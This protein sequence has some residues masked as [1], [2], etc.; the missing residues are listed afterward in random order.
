MP[1]EVTQNKK[2]NNQKLSIFLNVKKTHKAARQG[3]IK[4]Q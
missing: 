3:K 2:E 4:E 1:K